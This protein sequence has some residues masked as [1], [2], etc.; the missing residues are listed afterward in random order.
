MLSWR[1]YLEDGSTFDDSMG[2]PA[3]APAVGVLSIQQRTGCG[4]HPTEWLKGEPTANTRRPVEMLEGANW[5]WWRDY[6]ERWYRGDLLGL[7]DQSMHAGAR[8]VKQGR[9]A[10]HET[11]ERTMM[12]VQEDADFR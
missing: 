8:F 9:V 2:G 4:H 10:A 1:I 7:L 6:T 3:D 11:W 12:A 5:Y